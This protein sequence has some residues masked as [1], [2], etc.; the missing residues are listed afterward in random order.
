MSRRRRT[1]SRRRR[2]AVIGGAAGLV[3]ATSILVGIWTIG[4]SEDTVRPS[5][6]R[7]LLDLYAP[8][9]IGG[10]PPAASW[11]TDVRDAEH[12]WLMNEA[13]GATDVGSVGGKDL[14]DYNSPRKEVIPGIPVTGG[15]AIDIT[16]EE[17]AFFDSTAARLRKLTTGHPSGTACSMTVIVN[18][19]GGAEAFIVDN[20]SAQGVNLSYTALGEFNAYVDGS[21][22]VG[23]V[24]SSA[25]YPGAW[26][27]VTFALDTVVGSSIYVDG[28]ED[29]AVDQS[30]GDGDL[31]H[32]TA[33]LY[34]GGQAGSKPLLGGI[35]RARHD[36]GVKVTLAQHQT[37]CGS[38]WD[39]NVA[40]SKVA[41]A[42]LTWT[43]TGA[44]RCLMQSATTALCIPGGFPSHAYSA[45]LSGLIWAPEPDRTNRVL[46][47]TA[48]DC[49]NWTCRGTASVT[50]GKVAPDGSATATEVVV[51]LIAND[52]R[53]AAS[54]SGYSNSVPLF[55]QLW[56]KCS[57]GTFRIANYLGGTEGDWSINCATIGGVWA[58]LTTNH[59]AVTEVQ[60]WDSN[61]SGQAGYSFSSLGGSVTAEVWAPTLVE[62]A[63]G[64]S[65]IPTAT[66]AQATGSIVW[67]VDN[68]PATYY[69][70]TRGKITLVAD[71]GTGACLDVTSGTNVG[72]QYGDAVDWFAYDSASTL[73]Y[74]ANLALAGPDTVVV[75]WNSIA[76]LSTGYYAQVLLNDIA[77]TWD[78]TPTSG[79]TSADPTKIQLSGYAATKCAAGI[80]RITI[81]DSP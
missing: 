50:T 61:A 42:D 59:P 75:R 58:Q 28:V 68:S 5:T 37:L 64:L 7:V 32:A 54:S 36:N 27:C 53:T 4:G 31:G 51:N 60:T 13:S 81:E 30:V 40:A 49:T 67:E 66:S 18:S 17:A 62:E 56:V 69:Q 22:G 33:H 57:S 25:G 43:Q 1:T 14:T 74:Q 12:C 47:S 26:H 11:C 38:L 23:N 44:G 24:R 9:D 46:Y 35:A 6:T 15:A 10:I 21:I 41:A 77:Q 34:F 63:A 79:W 72:R 73:V 3:L 8:R 20:R 80:Q 45:G 78:M 65:T 55:N 76:P 19:S 52:V 48:I 39:F 71:Y 16:T 29:T 70:G 2:N